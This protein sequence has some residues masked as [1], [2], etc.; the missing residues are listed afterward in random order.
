VD[1]L[2]RLIIFGYIIRVLR[3]YP[4]TLP[5][6]VLGEKRGGHCYR[7]RL[8]PLMRENIIIEP[9]DL[10]A[11]QNDRIFTYYSVNVSYYHKEIDSF[12]LDQKETDIRH[13]S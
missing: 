7:L 8:K 13:S 9:N 4:L 10:D 12:A 3:P 1:L 11:Y 5:F 6:L 2:A